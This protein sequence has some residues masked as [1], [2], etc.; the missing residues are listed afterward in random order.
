MDFAH[1]LVKFRAHTADLLLKLC[2][3]ATDLLLEA[4]DLLP[5]LYPY[6]ADLL[7]ELYPYAADLLL[8]LYPYAADLF[9]ELYPYAADL[10]LKLCPYA[11]DL[12]PD[13]TDL[14]LHIQESGVHLATQ[15]ITRL[16]YPAS[17]ALLNHGD[18]IFSLLAVHLTEQIHQR[19]A[20][21][22]AQLVS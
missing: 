18:Q 21:R 14:L 5:E 9:P 15:L 3:Y 20:A 6:A 22:V 1:L 13:A 16:H 19:L 2:P 11:T 8:E 12:L 17:E 10:L 7:L 4:T